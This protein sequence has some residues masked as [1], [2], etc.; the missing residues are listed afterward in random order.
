M[1]SANNVQRDASILPRVYGQ[2]MLATPLDRVV[3]L[4]QH[5]W[6]AVV[7]T[8]QRAQGSCL[9]AAARRLGD[10]RDA[11]PASDTHGIRY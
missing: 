8:H 9:D 10:C 5:V 1:S 7:R 4:A 2:K 3:G 11:L 6:E